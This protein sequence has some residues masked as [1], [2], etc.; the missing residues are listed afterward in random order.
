MMKKLSVKSEVVC[1]SDLYGNHL[2]S[3]SVSFVSCSYFVVICVALNTFLLKNCV[4]WLDLGSLP[5]NTM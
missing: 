5:G 1:C 3:S 2:P 4:C